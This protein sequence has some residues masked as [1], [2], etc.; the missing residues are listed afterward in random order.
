M[1]ARSLSPVPTPILES[2]APPETDLPWVV[3]VLDKQRY[4]ISSEYVREMTTFSDYVSV[5]KA[6]EFVRGAISLRGQVMTLVDLRV[7][8]GLPSALVSANQL[9]EEM[10]K[11]EQ[12]HR[13][14]LDELRAS[15][16]QKREFKKTTDPHQCAFGR[17]YDNF[18]TDNAV[19]R[20]VLRR[21]DAPHKAIHGVAINALAAEERGDAKEAMAIIEETRNTTLSEMIKLFGEFRDA[22]KNSMREIAV[23]IG[24]GDQRCAVVVDSVESVEPLKPAFDSTTNMYQ[25]AGRA[26]IPW[27]GRRLKD[28]SSVLLPDVNL[29]LEQI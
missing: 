25:E 24:K 19:F 20:D 3:F 28:D 18:K 21:F 13:D 22:L 7:W 23:I 11:R 1:S 8:V 5:P 9:V 29:L 6:S 2:A 10:H 15:I 12:D 17:W 26:N 16:E 27:L 14:W 4:A